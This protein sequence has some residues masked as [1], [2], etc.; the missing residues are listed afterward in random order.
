MNRSTAAYNIIAAYDDMTDARESLRRLKEAGVR[1]ENVSLLGRHG[2]EIASS[3]EGKTDDR[4]TIT[5]AAV[6]TV[7]GA[8]GGGVLGGIAG[9]LVGLAT[10][11][12]PGVG[13]VLTAG[14]WGAT[15]LG[16]IGGGSAG[17]L[18]GAISGAALSN[19][20]D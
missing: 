1:G 20:K 3:D 4:E 13:P 15:A 10:L 6:G 9:F 8:A 7:A 18:I 11:A 12:V 2:E 19:D 16:A 17:S 5:D 14:V